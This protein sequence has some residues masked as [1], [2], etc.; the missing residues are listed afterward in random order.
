VSFKHIFSAVWDPPP[1][2]RKKSICSIRQTWR[3]W[4]WWKACLNW[5]VTKYLIKILHDLTDDDF[6]IFFNCRSIDSVAS[7]QPERQSSS[8]T[9]S[10]HLRFVKEDQRIAISK[11]L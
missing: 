7:M 3:T 8:I 1:L 2:Y 5:L 11:Y 9:T 4:R 6:R 10:A